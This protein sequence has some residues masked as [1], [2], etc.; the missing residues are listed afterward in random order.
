M[1]RL[2]LLLLG[3]LATLPA[4]ATPPVQHWRSAQG[5]DVYFIAADTLPI[6]DLRLTFRAGAARDGEQPGLAAL[7]NSL[8]DQGAGGRS[9]DELAQAL[10]QVGA[11]LNIGSARDMAW[12]HLRSLSRAE[13]L[14]PALDT[15]ELILT[16]P[17][18]P[19]H[20]LARERRRMLVYLRSQQQSPAALAEKAFYKALYGDHPYA[21]PPAGTAE[22]LRALDEEDLREFYRRHYVAANATVALVG[23]LTRSQAEH[24]V[25]RLLDELPAGEAPPALPEVPPAET[26]A[27][28]IPFDASQTHILLGQPAAS[29]DSPDY[30]PLLV[31][32]HILGGSGLNSVLAR[33]LREERGLSYSSASRFSFMERPGPFLMSTQVRADRADE[34]LGVLHDSLRSLRDEG[35]SQQQLDMA[36][37]NLAGG[38]PLQLDSN[39][40]LVGYLSVIGFYGLPLDY[41]ERYV[42]RV[43]AVSAEE[44]REAFRRHLDPARMTRVLVGPEAAKTP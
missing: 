16:Q 32:N 10:E 33:E 38:F 8:L 11:R 4:L 35:P 37:A 15:L 3:L 25:G 1:M 19:A 12:L 44:I 20:A 24:L 22:S 23:D 30:F 18:F 21:T 13:A 42:S 6:V 28:H 17:D 5:A 27:V 14:A 31:G 26:Q 34:A 40:D 2:T 7:T 9:A 41:L 36:I 29:R 43:R 39:N